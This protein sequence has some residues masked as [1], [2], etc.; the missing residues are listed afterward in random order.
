MS[1]V[2]G[3]QLSDVIP[4]SRMERDVRSCGQTLARYRALGL[5]RYLISQCGRYCSVSQTGGLVLYKK[6]RRLCLLNEMRQKY[7]VKPRIYFSAYMSGCIYILLFRPESRE[8]VEPVK[9]R[10]LLG[11]STGLHFEY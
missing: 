3:H 2:L 1:D 6:R 5:T 10:D 4:S 7:H 8:P 9:Y 11:H